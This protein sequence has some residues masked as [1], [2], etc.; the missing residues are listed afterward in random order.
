MTGRRCYF[1]AA[2]DHFHTFVHAQQ[3]QMLVSTGAQRPRDIE[4][5]AVVR[6]G[7]DDI[8]N[9]FPDAYFHMSCSGMPF[10]IRECLLGHAEQRRTRIVGQFMHVLTELRDDFPVIRRVMDVAGGRLFRGDPNCEKRRRLTDLSRLPSGRHVCQYFREQNVFVENCQFMRRH[11]SR[12][13]LT[14]QRPRR[15]GKSYSLIEMRP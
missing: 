1:K 7:H 9:D 3:S 14:G 4:R 5:F 10:D 11:S 8:V 6:D 2:A 15:F 13:N 12:K